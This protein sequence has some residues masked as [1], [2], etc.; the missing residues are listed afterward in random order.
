MARKKVEKIIEDN[1]NYILEYWN[2]IKNKEIIVCEK[3]YKLYER[4]AYESQNVIRDRW[5]FD[6]K[7]ASYAIRFIEKFM[8]CGK[9]KFAK[10]RMKLLLYQKA[11]IS[12]IFGFIDK[13][14]R[15][16]RYKDVLLVM[17]RKNG[18]TGLSAAIS[19][20]LLTEEY[21]GEI[22][23]AANTASQASLLF[24]DVMTSIRLCDSF[25]S[26][27]KKR[28]SDYIFYP[29]NSTIKYVAGDSSNL[30]GL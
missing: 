15:F 24:N 17:A 11:F 19:Q 27:G 4:L 3:I 18:K 9:G 7:K 5:V 30:D 12:T 23:C 22:Y 28:K 6:Q 10:K 13:D 21:G 25:A 8:Y 29:T 14:T 1:T 20:L 16:R 2:A 26:N